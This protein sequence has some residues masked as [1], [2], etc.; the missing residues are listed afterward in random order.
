MSTTTTTEDTATMFCDVCGDDCLFHR[1]T[2]HRTIEVRGEGIC[3]AEPVWECAVCRATQPDLSSGVD[4]L[5][6]AY[7]EYRARHN[8]LT[9]EQI[10]EIR[11]R[12]TLS[13]DAFTSILGISPATLDRY[14]RGALQDELH[15]TAIRQCD[16]PSTMPSFA[17]TH[18]NQI[19]GP[20]W[21][22]FLETIGQLITRE[23]ASIPV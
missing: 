14:E 18:R 22:R 4:S 17:A 3:I 21:K 11:E 19:P 1:V 10:L 13:L 12:Y 16:V 6:L 15:D 2:I 23:A 9:P 8:L 7:R 5:T 20:Q